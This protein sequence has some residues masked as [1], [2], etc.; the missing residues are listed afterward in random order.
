MFIE[1]ETTPNPATLKFL[2]GQEVM[3]AGTREFTGRGRCRGIAAG[4]RCS[5][6]ATY[7]VSCSGAISCRLRPV[8]VSTG[9]RSSRRLSHAARSLRDRARRCSRRTA[10]GIA[11][12]AEDDADVA[13]IPPM[14]M[15]SP[16]SRN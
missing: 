12:G 3:Y 13:M 10:S 8:K 6:W 1:T 4:Q 9:R 14:P 11:V 7:R 5:I 16:R 2:P 15:W